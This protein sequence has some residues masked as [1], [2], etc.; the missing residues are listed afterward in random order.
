MAGSIEL[1]ISRANPVRN[2]MTSWTETIRNWFRWRMTVR[3]SQRDT[4][5]KDGFSAAVIVIGNAL[6]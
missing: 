6:V 1:D 5:E 3:I 2:F 4:T